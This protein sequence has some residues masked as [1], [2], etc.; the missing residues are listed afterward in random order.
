MD[1]CWKVG[2]SEERVGEQNL[3]DNENNVDICMNTK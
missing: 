3:R 1:D 2:G